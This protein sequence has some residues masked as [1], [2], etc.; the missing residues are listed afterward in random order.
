MTKL[1]FDPEKCALH[2]IGWWR[3]HHEK[4][5]ELVISEMAKLY[6]EL[7]GLEFEEAKGIVILRIEAAK[8]HDK[9]ETEDITDEESE[10]HWRKAEEFM[11]KHFELLFESL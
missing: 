3:A 7:Y 9:A 5:Y 1:T 6:A 10:V 8:E 2:E 11:Q 4:N